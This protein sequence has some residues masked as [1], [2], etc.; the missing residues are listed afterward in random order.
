MPALFG[1]FAH[2]QQKA[3]TESPSVYAAEA[4]DGILK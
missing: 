4:A 3:L 1:S 2:L